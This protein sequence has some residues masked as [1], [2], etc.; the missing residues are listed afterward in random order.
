MTDTEVF[1][2]AAYLFVGFV[3]GFLIVRTGDCESPV[4]TWCFATF[5]GP[6]CL[7]AFAVLLA[8]LLP[9]VALCW[10]LDIDSSDYD[11]RGT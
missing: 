8:P 1:Y 10:M 2:V 11:N 5:A 4:E 7:A 9:F 6:I 3:M